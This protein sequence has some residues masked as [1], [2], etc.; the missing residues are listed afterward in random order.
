MEVVKEKVLST[1]L[2]KKRKFLPLHQAIRDGDKDFIEKLFHYKCAPKVNATNKFGLT[3]LH[4]AVLRNEEEI[5]K[6]LISNGANVNAKSSESKLLP[7][8]DN[9]VEDVRLSSFCDKREY[10]RLTPL[11]LAAL[12]G[13]VEIAQEFIKNGS[14]VNEENDMG[15]RPIEC[16]VHSD[17]KEMISLLIANNAKF[18]QFCTPTRILEMA[19]AHGKAEILEL[20]LE[21]KTKIEHDSHCLTDA[22]MNGFQYV[23]DILLN[24]GVDILKHDSLGIAPIHC[25]I[26]EG[27]F[28]TV[29]FLLEKGCNPD[30]YNFDTGQ[31]P[32]QMAIDD[33]QLETVEL[34]IKY[35]ADLNYSVDDFGAPL[36]AAIG[37]EESLAMKMLIDSGAN[38]EVRDLDDNTPMELGLESGRI[39]AV[40]MLLFHKHC[41]P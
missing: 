27:Y 4:I 6:I 10:L 18:K 12:N 13:S 41:L 14:N 16:A 40:K 38:S 7:E 39:S 5:V 17:C 15:I 24:N 9:N 29:Q 36:H 25:A 1:P 3:P 26:E 32:L 23:L 33:R 11:H 20:M 30:Q 22:T 35:G 21:Q 31:L 8:V 28:E 19:A 37:M 2:K 34:L